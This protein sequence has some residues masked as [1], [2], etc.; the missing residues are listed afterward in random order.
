MSL[1]DP[2]AEENLWY[3]NSSVRAQNSNRKTALGPQWSGGPGRRSYEDVMDYLF[4]KSVTSVNQ[5]CVPVGERWDPSLK[6]MSLPLCLNHQG[7]FIQREHTDAACRV[8]AHHPHVTAADTSRGHSITTETLL[9]IHTFF[10][11]LWE[12]TV[13]SGA[14]RVPYLSILPVDQSN[15]RARRSAPT[16]ALLRACRLRPPSYWYTVMSA[17]NHISSLGSNM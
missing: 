4:K 7:A 13:V 14:H 6:V 9:Q 8:T 16:A 17:D 1:L 11:L 15:D 10:V 2:T 12:T 5:L 3:H